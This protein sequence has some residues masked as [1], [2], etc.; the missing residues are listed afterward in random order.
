MSAPELWMSLELGLIYGL[1]SMGIYL[2]F[3]ILNF[4]DLTCD[5]SFVLGAAVSAVL[6]KAGYSPWTSLGASAIVGG[7]AGF[8]TGILHTRFRVSDLLS[9]ILVAFMLYSINL[10]IMGG[11]PNI[12]LMEMH[13]ISTHFLWVIVL[14]IGFFFAYLLKTDWGLALRSLGKNKR[15][16]LNNGI[17]VPL[18][19]VA[20]LALSN[21]LIAMG[22]SL[23]GQYQG[24]VD[25]GSGVGSV[26][27]GLAS[28]MIGECFVP[29]RSVVW[30]LFSAI[31]GSILYR[32]IISLALHSDIFGLQ[33]QDLNL[34][35]GLLIL[36]IMIS[37][38]RTS[39]YR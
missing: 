15:L 33:T 34:I 2:S 11:S 16:G 28:I 9:G 7:G 39:C 20:G 29:T 23:M 37:S 12:N 27:I 13:V 22:G 1:V 19:I 4:S 5:G 25:I 24:F 8:I 14:G 31:I 21:A 32:I 35:T 38:R 36:T 18:M 26:I 3:R 17:R 6:I 10:R 30:A